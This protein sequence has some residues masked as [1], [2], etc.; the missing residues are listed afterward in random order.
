MDYNF[1]PSFKLGSLNVNNIIEV[2]KERVEI[3][4]LKPI[5]IL[6]EKR[7][8]FAATALLA[9]LID[10][11]VKTENHN[12]TNKNGEQYINW[13]KENLR[14]K[15]QLAKK[16]YIN[17]RCGLLHAGCIE[18]GGQI[19]YTQKELYLNTDGYLSVNPELLYQEVSRKINKYINE[20]DPDDLFK[21]LKQRLR[22]I[23]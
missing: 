2:F 23:D 13:I 3:Y 20:E 11:L 17:F 14:F 1:S 16:F 9:S 8:G 7:C 6:N 19:S 4:Y 10:I 12:V 22:E 18:S 5:K 21:Y 15:P